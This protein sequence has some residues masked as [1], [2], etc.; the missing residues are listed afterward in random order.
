MNLKSRIKKI[1]KKTSKTYTKKVCILFGNETQKQGRKKMNL[2]DDVDII[3]IKVVS[4]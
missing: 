4:I 3:Y 2:I 1:E